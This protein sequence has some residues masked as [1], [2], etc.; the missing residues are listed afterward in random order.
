MQSQGYKIVPVRP[1]VDEV[2]GEKAYA[3]LSDIP[4]E[5]DIVNI[6]RKPEHVGPIVDE[7]IQKKAK[8]IWMQLG[9]SNDDAAKK[10]ADAGLEV[11]QDRCMLIEHRR[12]LA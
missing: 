11:V 8:T 4:F 9:I 5:I 7:A 2:L 3:S 6:F 12:L 10:A 1:G